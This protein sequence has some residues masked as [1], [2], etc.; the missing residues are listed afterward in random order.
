MIVFSDSQ[1][2]LRRAQGDYLGPGQAIA[3][4]IIAKAQELTQKRVKVIL[5]WVPSY[6]GIEGN[7]KADQAA[8]QAANKFILQSIKR[9][10]SFSYITRLIKAKR[11][12]EIKK[13]LYKITYKGQNKK[14]DR[15]Y[16]LSESLILNSQVLQARKDVA[17][18]Y[19]QLKIGHA[20]TVSYLH[21][22]KR[23]ESTECWLVQCR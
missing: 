1:A 18:R 4:D 2:A 13:W 5:K 21:R 19:F 10:S 14:R 16:S 11:Q 8:K 3:I 17:K 20:I 6:I 7:E 15:A 12:D 9:Y 23:L 22:I